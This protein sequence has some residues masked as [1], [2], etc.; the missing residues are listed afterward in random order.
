MTEM[1]IL[2]IVVMA[3]C[4]LCGGVALRA[5]IRA[6]D[7]EDFAHRTLNTVNEIV[8]EE[9]NRLR[10]AEGA[11]RAVNEMIQNL[12]KEGEAIRAELEKVRSLIPEDVKEERT[13]RNVLMSQLNDELEMRIRAEQEWNA[14]V[15]SVLGYDLN[16]ARAAGVKNNDE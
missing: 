16:K 9:R 2:A 13:R 14:M 5:N 4:G 15:S 1:I 7:A 8:Q 10:S 3:F 11:L 6:T 12:R